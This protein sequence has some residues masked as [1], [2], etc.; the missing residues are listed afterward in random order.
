[1]SNKFELRYTN[2]A[3]KEVKKLDPDIQ[4]QVIEAVEVLARNPRPQNS[5]RLKHDLSDYRKLRTGNYR[6]IY[7]V[8]DEELKI[9][10]VRAGH[11]KDIYD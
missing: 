10:V 2:K 9:I 8:K 7:Q 5:E 6:V 4:R 3:F 11:R 1:M